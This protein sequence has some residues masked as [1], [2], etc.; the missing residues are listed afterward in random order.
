MEIEQIKARRDALIA[1]QA[2][3][4][5]SFLSSKNVS[6]LLKKHTKLLDDLLID[7]WK[8]AALSHDISLIAVGGYGREELFPHSDID[9]LILV[10]EH[11][12]DAQNKALEALVGVL[13][14]LGLNVGHSVRSLQECIDEASNDVTIQTNLLEARLI[15]GQTATFNQFVDA[16]KHK[17][18]IKTFLKNKIAEQ[19]DRHAK[20]NDT[21]YNLEPNIKEGKGGLRDL[22]TILW[23][24]NSL[25]LGKSWQA[26]AANGI[27]SKQELSAIRTNENTLNTLRIRI[28][29]L[30]KRREDRLLFDFQNEL[31]ANLGLVNTD[32]KRASEQLMQRYY[33]SVRY[34][35][36]MNEILVKLFTEKC[37]PEQAGVAINDDLLA[38][39]NLLE[40]AS[41]NLFDR[42]PNAILECFLLLQTHPELDGFGPRLLRELKNAS[43]LVTESFRKSPVNQQLFLEIL[44]QKN[45]VHHSLRRM[46]RCGILGKYIPAFGKIIGQMQH[47]LFHVYTVD[48]HT[49]NVLANLRRFSK[50]ELAHE[51]PLCSELFA[52]F[53][54]PHL[55]Y[56]AAIFHDIAKGRGGDHSELGRVD[57]L[58][59]CKSHQ[60]PKEDGELVA[61]L[62]EAHLQHSKVAQKSDLSDPAVIE[63]YAQFVENEPRLTALYLLTVA[64]V[65]GTSPVVWNDWKATLLENLFTETKQAL[66]NDT[67]NLKKA[68]ADR[69]QLAAEKLSQFNLTADAYKPLWDNVGEAYFTRHTD[70]E[71]TWHS[72]LLTPHTFTK[73]PIVRAQLSRNGDGVQIM[74]YTPNQKDLFAR[75]CNFFDRLGFNIGEAK[76][77]TTDHNYAL[78]TFI[79]LVPSDQE[80]SYNGLLKHIEEALLEKLQTNDMI[81]DPIKGRITRQVKHMPIKTDVRF[82]TSEE[83]H[84]QLLD[85][86]TS[87]RPGLLATIAFAFLEHEVELHNAKINTLGNRAEDSFLISNKQDEPLNVQEMQALERTLTQYLADNSAAA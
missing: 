58:N 57:A 16:V 80:L 77:Y 38:K 75:I 82:E 70:N 84:H 40:V 18:D 15:A 51:F 14:D 50:P 6:N 78:N 54:K 32:K 42:K 12:P 3:L 23:L 61:W 27:I 72:R 83:N 28:H 74:I 10:P 49:L 26:L 66:T 53:K 86:I 85:I 67:F 69:Q 71:I 17:L 34:I 13:W 87:D 5:Q 64:D 30:A 20:S 31:A 1:Q 56:L 11:M 73:T 76:I 81:E 47:D 22:H 36:L 29:Y 4:E 35:S 45:G 43:K 46:N 19:D 2:K 44:K 59:F 39:N 21:G 48:E 65:R 62:V 24:A 41:P 79:I 37:L 60:L 8:Y 25:N 52:Q 68:I 7:V 55:L 33:K 9:L 63:Q